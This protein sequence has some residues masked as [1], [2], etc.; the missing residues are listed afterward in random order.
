MFC[1]GQ[2]DGYPYSPVLWALPEPSSLQP[3]LREACGQKL[4]WTMSRAPQEGPDLR[5][6]AQGSDGA[7]LLAAGPLRTH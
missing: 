6:G 3:Q 4:I 1:P 7:G 2:L 5:G